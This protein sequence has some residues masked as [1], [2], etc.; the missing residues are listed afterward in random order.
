M[1][2]VLKINDVDRSSWVDWKSFEK[3]EVLTKET[4]RLQFEIR[5]IG[6]RTAPALGDK[7]TVLYGA[8][9][10]FEGVVVEV[11]EEIRGGI[12][13]GWQIKCKDWT[14]TLDKKLVIKSYTNQTAAA[15][16][17]DIITTYC[18]GFTTNNVV[19]PVNVAS[20]KFNYEFVSK[21]LQQLSDLLD[22]D[23]Y[24]DYDKDIH[25]FSEEQNT[26]PFNLDDTSGNYKFGSLE[27]NK[28]IL[29]IKNTIYIRGGEY[30]GNLET[31]IWSADGQQI[32][33]DLPYSLDEITVKKGGV[34]QSIGTD[35]VTDPNLV[36]CLYNFNEKQIKFRSD[37]KPGSGVAVEISGKPWI[38]VI[39]KISD[40]ESITNYGEYEFAI[41]DKSIKTKDEA[42][43][44]G[45]AA[46]RKF[47]ETV[48][49]A[50]FRTNKVGLRTGQK[51]RV[52]SDIR[53]IDKW[54]MVNRVI[55]RTRKSDE[56][57]YEI[58]LIAS[59]NVTFIDMM[60]GLLEKDKKNIVIAANEILDKIETIEDSVSI[61]ESVSR[62]G[63]KNVLESAS[64]GESIQMTLKTPPFKWMPDAVNPA[65]WNLFSWY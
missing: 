20:I 21:C 61:A 32:T 43:N 11:L 46:L 53:G 42:K 58:F 8:S 18:P 6:A 26:T 34:T 37:N 63:V 50:S 54:F 27:I 2:I 57:E 19:A 59:G 7:I 23:W 48:W 41:I 39:A 55:S 14:H 17:S 56:F 47:G 3:V 4:D 25:F 40:W 51:I 15:I 29:Q 44:R 1:P 36:D 31:F 22:Y 12:L 13:I 10:I 28:N 52:Q 38:P 64:I 65:K 45:K 5:K 35:F 9:K 60:T 16:I 62:Y 30:K 49:E 24:V 33:F